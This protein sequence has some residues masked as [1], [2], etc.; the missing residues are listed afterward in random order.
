MLVTL[1]SGDGI[2][3]K[4]LDLSVAQCAPSKLEIIAVLPCMM[5]A[6]IQLFANRC[7]RPRTVLHNCYR[8][9]SDFL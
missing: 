1:P 4:A 5:V 2:M 6:R 8:P 7:K 9:M 3:L